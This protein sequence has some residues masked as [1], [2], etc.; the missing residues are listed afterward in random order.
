MRELGIRRYRFTSRGRACSLTAAARSNQ[1][2]STTTGASS[3][4][5]SARHRAVSD[6]LPLGSAAGAPGRGRLGGPGVIGRFAEY[7]EAVVRALG[8]RV[9]LDRAQRAAGL[10]HSSATSW[11]STRRAS[12][13]RPRPARSATSSTSRTPRRSAAV[14]AAAPGRPDRDPPQHGVAYPAPTTRPTRRPPSASTRDGTRGSSTRCCAARTRRRSST[15]TRRSARDG[16]PAGRHRAIAQPTR[17]H[18]PQHLPRAI[19]AVD[20]RQRSSASREVAGPG[21]RT[22]SAGRSGPAALTELARAARA[23]STAT[24][25]CYI[26]ENGCASP[27]GPTPEAAIDERRVEYLAAHIGQRARAHREASTSAATTSGRCSTTSSG[28]GATTQRFGIV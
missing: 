6:A 28:S 20:R 2:G 26:T 3:R 25:R 21:R 8:D 1:R 22:S 15:R 27:T 19:V 13:T 10:R 24:C 18:R 4:S 23:A 16:H 17:L 7:V 9:R 14:R 12:G 5:C 11:A